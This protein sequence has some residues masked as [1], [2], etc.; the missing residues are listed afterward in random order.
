M[1]IHDYRIIE[2]VFQEIH[3]QV[4]DKIP[5]LINAG[6]NIIGGCCGTTPEHIKKIF[7]IIN[8]FTQ[9]ND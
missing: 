2:I 1:L 5:D 4:A 3:E 9:N 6:A 7:G 8:E